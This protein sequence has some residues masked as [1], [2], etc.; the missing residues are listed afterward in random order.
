MMP[1]IGRRP[2]P[3][4]RWIRDG[5]S[6]SQPAYL[7]CYNEPDNPSQSNTST[8]DAIAN[9][10]ALEALDVPLVGPA[11]Q[12]TEDDWENC[13]YSLIASNN[14]RVDYAAV[15]EYVPPNAGSVIAD[16]QSVYNAYGRPVW[17][18]EF[19]PVDWSDCQC[20]SED[21]DYNFL[22]EFMWQAENQTWLR[23]YSVF[24]FSNTNPDSPWVDN[25]FTGSI[26]LANGQTLS[27]YGELYATWDGDES[28][29]AQIPYIIHNLGT[30][31]RLTE[32]NDSSTPVA[33]TIYV[34][35]ATT[36]WALLAA[37]DGNW[38]IISLNDGRRLS[39]TNGVLG[40]APPG[41]T[42]LTVEWAFNGPDPSGYYYISNPA[43]GHN[44]KRRRHSPGHQFQSGEFRNRDQQHAMAFCK[45]LPTGRA[46]HQSAGAAGHFIYDARK[47]QCDHGLVRRW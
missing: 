34:R 10:P 38:Y 6:N 26:F 28:L 22:A 9:W 39:D 17:L 37:V 16:C 14:Y 45:T 20:W 1:S 12:N 32:A 24:P 11:V 19:S 27:P 40:L 41:T 43:G 15:H 5:S 2:A 36:E 30:S 25:G 3:P 18:T 44:L 46:Q 8:N 42:G 33:S 29:H 7:L 13:F 23:R 21:D 31:F 35:N 47:R 4:N